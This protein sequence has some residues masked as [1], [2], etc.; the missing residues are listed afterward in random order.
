MKRDYKHDSAFPFAGGDQSNPDDRFI[1]SGLSKLEYIAAMMAQALVRE[2]TATNRPIVT[3]IVNRKAIEI[4]DS[5][6]TELETSRL[7]GTNGPDF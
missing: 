5:L 1:E 3:E 6:L 7:V 4:A 2:Y